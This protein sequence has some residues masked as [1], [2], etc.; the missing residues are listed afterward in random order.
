MG[1]INLTVKLMVLSILPNIIFALF[2]LIF[3]LGDDKPLVN[4]E[5]FGLSGF[6]VFNGTD[7]NAGLLIGVAV[8]ALLI[9]LAAIL[10]SALVYAA[11]VAS[12]LKILQGHTVSL[13]EALRMGWQVLGKMVLVG[14]TMAG[15]FIGILVVTLLPAALSP[16]TLILAIPIGL[17]AMVLVALWLVYALPLVVDQKLSV[18]NAF[19]ESKR[20]FK[21]RPSLPI[22]WGLVSMGIT[23]GAFAVTLPIM[24]VL[25]FLPIIGDLFGDFIG[26][27]IGVFTT[28]GSA[29]LYVAVKKAYP[30]TTDSDGIVAGHGSKAN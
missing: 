26:G 13:S 19:R 22:L 10:F 16:L 3:Y 17:V 25:S 11:I 8:V 15:L 29:A 2:G 21:A 28:V 27:I 18:G 1:N 6:D 12:F 9:F 24:V 5:S 14:L 7:V 30:S 23:M 20:L 4:S